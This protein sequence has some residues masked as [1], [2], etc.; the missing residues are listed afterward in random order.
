MSP[1]LR[2]TAC[3]TLLFSSTYSR[4]HRHSGLSGGSHHGLMHSAKDA[5]S[6]PRGAT[7]K[8]ESTK[9]RR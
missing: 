1:T 2:Y 7:Y 4:S 6:T 3:A 5:L 8:S 9:T